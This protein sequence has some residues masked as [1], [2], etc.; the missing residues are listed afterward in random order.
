MAALE[1]ALSVDSGWLKPPTL[2]HQTACRRIQNVKKMKQDITW[3][4]IV[5]QTA[6]CSV[7]ICSI[8]ADRNK[9][10]RLWPMPNDAENE[11]FSLV[12]NY[13]KE[14]NLGLSHEG[15]R[16]F[17]LRT[18]FAQG[19]RQHGRKVEKFWKSY[20]FC[21]SHHWELICLSW[22]LKLLKNIILVENFVEI[23]HA[24]LLCRE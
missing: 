1:Q 4:E 3:C 22:N 11:T 6:E 10:Q 20:I 7:K 24:D 5:D 23:F 13:V 9:G 16:D 8:L 15:F 19:G 12:E 18:K 17:L 2:R 21:L 14:I